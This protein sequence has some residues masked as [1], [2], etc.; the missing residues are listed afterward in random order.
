M[1][2]SPRWRPSYYRR[3]SNECRPD[4][5]HASSRPLVGFGTLALAGGA[6]SGTCATTDA[7][8]ETSCG[9]YAAACARLRA[10]AEGRAERARAST[11]E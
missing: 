3:Q 10:S 6:V 11:A 9:R 7:R 2:T 8:S 1:R 4:A 5:P